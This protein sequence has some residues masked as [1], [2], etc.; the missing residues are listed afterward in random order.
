MITMSNISRQVCVDAPTS[1][2]S[3]LR[4]GASPRR[5]VRRVLASTGLS[6]Q[7]TSLSTVSYE[8]GIR[9]GDVP[10]TARSFRTNL[11]NPTTQFPVPGTT[12]WSPPVL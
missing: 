3:E 10:R 5:P 6:H 11:T 9:K 12:A 1:V 7:G 4:L 8:G 2:P